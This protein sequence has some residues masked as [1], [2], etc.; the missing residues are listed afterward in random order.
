MENPKTYK[1]PRFCKLEECGS[2]HDGAQVKRSLGAESEPYL[3][4]FC[5]A[6]CY[7]KHVMTLKDIHSTKKL[8][9]SLNEFVKNGGRLITGRKIFSEQDSKFEFGTF[10][11]FDEKTNSPL[12][13]NATYKTCPINHTTFFVEIEVTPIYK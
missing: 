12:I 4:G 13:K 3:Q 11:G 5:C 7:T 1:E 8:R 2:F 9:V 10:I 6:R